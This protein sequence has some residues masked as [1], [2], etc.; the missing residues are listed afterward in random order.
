MS[1]P[2]F[3]PQQELD[4][5]YL[6]RNIQWR[7]RLDQAEAEVIARI[8]RI[9][10]EIREELTG[11]ISLYAQKTYTRA[12]LEA[13]LAE[14]EVLRVAAQ[15]QTANVI[16]ETSGVVGALSL[17]EQYNIVSVGGLAKNVKALDMGSSSLSALFL[18]TPLGGRGLQDWVNRAF[19][20]GQQHIVD[21]IQKGL[22]QGEGYPKIIRRVLREAG[23]L[24]T[25]E[26]ITLT[27][28]YVQSASVSAQDPSGII[29]GVKQAVREI[30]KVGEA[31]DEMSVKGEKASDSFSPD[32]I[33]QKAKEAQK[34][35]KELGK[36]FL[37]TEKEALAAIAKIDSSFSQF[38]KVIDKIRKAASTLNSDLSDINP[39][40]ERDG[41]ARGHSG[42]EL[43][44][45]VEEYK[46]NVK[47]TALNSLIEGFKALQTETKVSNTSLVELAKTL[48]IGEKH[49]EALG[50]QA[51]GAG[52]K[53]ATAGKAAT[54]LVG[55][56]RS[57]AAGN[58]IG[59]AIS[60]VVS[61][62]VALT[63]SFFDGKK[64][65]QEYAELVRK[66]R[67]ELEKLSLAS[68]AA[69][70]GTENLARVQQDTLVKKAQRRLDMLFEQE[71]ELV[72]RMRQAGTATSG[73]CSIL[74]GTFQSPL[75]EVTSFPDNNYV[76]T[77]FQ[78]YRKLMEEVMS[79]PRNSGRLNEIA[80]EIGEIGAALEKAGGSSAEKAQKVV[81]DFIAIPPRLRP[82]TV[83]FSS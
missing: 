41:R 38:P 37:Q 83:A 78:Q 45:Y 42:D 4:L 49:F 66:N 62:V 71:Q 74:W 32:K 68:I 76:N 20:G 65:A 53:M 35:V 60:L 1:L 24:T 3:T 30:E 81:Q 46:N 25:R 47:N 9:L 11:R 36:A 75:K 26:A 58:A 21:V 64:A 55:A 19:E 27:R 79:G 48:G 12:R 52:E 50:L 63:R 70:K 72:K 51:T 31:Y 23:H 44:S 7:Y 28:T 82:T 69:A 17:Q 33:T 29:K 16:A 15:A 43:T 39:F 56:L 14:V 59:L 5:Y 40:I 22:F 2:G 80:I 67:D 61:A 8:T 77:L 13:L 54:G 34:E 57:F 18:T 10:G 6:V 73:G